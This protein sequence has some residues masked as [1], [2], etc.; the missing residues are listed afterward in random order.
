VSGVSIVGCN[1]T[2]FGMQVQVLPTRDPVNRTSSKYK[3]VYLVPFEEC[4][5]HGAT[6]ENFNLTDVS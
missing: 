1:I 3:K 6:A 2:Q 4:D 5:Y